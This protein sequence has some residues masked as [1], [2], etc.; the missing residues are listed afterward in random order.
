MTDGS[1]NLYI[2]N[3]LTN[4]CA[5]ALRSGHTYQWYAV[6]SFTDNTSTTS[7]TWSFSMQ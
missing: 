7:D 2:A 5:P 4:S 1:G 6:A 3:Q